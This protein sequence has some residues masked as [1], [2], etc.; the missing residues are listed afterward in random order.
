LVAVEGEDAFP[1]RQRFFDLVAVLA[2]EG[3]LSRL[4]YTAERA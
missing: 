4:A 1:G 2:Q 3:R